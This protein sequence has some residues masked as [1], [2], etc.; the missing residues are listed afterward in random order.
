MSS[1]KTPPVRKSSKKIAD[2]RRVRFGGGNAPRV[3]RAQDA[4]TRD[5]GTIR[6]GGGNC[7]ASLRK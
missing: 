1:K 2:Q 5:A 7:P 3:L 4:A 6:F